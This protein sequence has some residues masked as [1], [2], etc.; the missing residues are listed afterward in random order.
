MISRHLPSPGNRSFFLFGPRMTGKSTWLA[1]EF[2]NALRI[3]LLNQE[4]YI[5]Y[6]ANPSLL[7]GEVESHLRR[8]KNG[9]ILIDE[10][11]RV[12][13][14]LN[15]VHRLIEDR[16]VRFGLSG[17]SARKLKRGGAN[18]LAGR[19]TEMR[20]FPFTIPELDASSTLASKSKFDLDSAIRWG[21]LPPVWTSELSEKKEILRSYASVYL[22]EE[23]QA[24][25]LVRNLPLTL[26]REW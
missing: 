22:R 10:I 7:E 20:I 15:E 19:A 24:E 1:H 17:S 13:D 21:T 18:L 8:N 26:A 14:L 4:N 11:Q 5:R 12:P 16:K 23:I 9:W 2:K 25:G 3:D 6:L